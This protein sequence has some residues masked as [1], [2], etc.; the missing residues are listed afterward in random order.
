MR[1]TLKVE[2][3]GVLLHGTSHVGP[4]GGDT[5]ILFLNSGT[6]PRSSR[7]DLYVHL[8]DALAEKGTKSFRVDLP[9]LGDSQGET[10]NGFIEFYKLVQ[11]GTQADC[12]VEIVRELRRRFALRGI[13]LMG[14]CG[15]AQTSVF[16]AGMDHGAGIAGL[17]LLDMPFFLYRDSSPPAQKNA[18]RSLG[19]RV[20]RGASG[21]KAKLHDW[22]LEQKWEPVATAV[23][24]RLRRLTR[25]THAGS[26]PPNT[27]VS[28]VQTLSDLVERGI[29]TLMIT[30]HPPIPE[31]P[32]FDY[33]GYLARRTGAGLTH[34]KIHG[35]THSFVEG[36]GAAAVLDAVSSWLTTI[37]PTP[38]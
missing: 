38:R 4:A 35:T 36:G 29:P 9:G 16:A 12:V 18:G 28:L 17:V 6:Q 7:G 20:R 23:Y 2:C 31:P 10:P 11:E 26:L 32:S 1:E 14:I 19:S 27:N 33:I 13:V 37:A 34:V 15:G 30:A 8:A 21:L 22:V 24:N 25:R 3:N 5:G